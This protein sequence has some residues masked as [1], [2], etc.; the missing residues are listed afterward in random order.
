[1]SGFEISINGERIGLVAIA[2]TGE[3]KP[4]VVSA[5]LT[6]VRRERSEASAAEAQGVT[7]F[8]VIGRCQNADYQTVNLTWLSQTLQIGDEIQIKVVEPLEIDPPM[9]QTQ[10]D[11]AF[12][13]QQRRRYYESL[14][15]HYE[16]HI[17]A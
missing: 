4:G 13:E 17:E 16:A 1:M 10:E 11:A 14:K 6:W 2:K 12:I 9:L 5:I 7:S 8:D 15:A 3:Q